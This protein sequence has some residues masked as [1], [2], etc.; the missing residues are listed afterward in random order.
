MAP[1]PSQSN[2]V[3]FRK[4]VPI[5]SAR[6]CAENEEKCATSSSKRVILIINKLEGYNVKEVGSKETVA[7]LEELNKIAKGRFALRIA[8][9]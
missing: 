9:V 7:P 1:K 8:T 3:T 6:K 5:I 2:L 4:G